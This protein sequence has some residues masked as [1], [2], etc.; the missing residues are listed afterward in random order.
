LKYS[1]INY[2]SEWDA[3]KLTNKTDKEGN[4]KRGAVLIPDTTNSTTV[5]YTYLIKEIDT[6]SHTITV[7]EDQTDPSNGKRCRHRLLIIYGQLIRDQI[8]DATN[9]VYRTVKFFD[10]T[11]TNS[12]ADGDGTRDGVCEVCHTKTRHFQNDGTSE[13][14]L[15][16][17]TGFGE[18]AGTACTNCHAHANGFA[19]GD[20]SIG[21]GC[22]RCHGHDAGTFY[23][24]DMSLP[25]AAGTEQS[26]GRGTHQSH[27][28][29]TESNSEISPSSAGEDDRRGPGIYCSTCHN[30]SKF[31]RFRSKADPN[32][33]LTLSQTDICDTCHSPDGTYNGV[34]DPVIGAKANWHDGIYAADG[35]LKAGKEKW[36]AGCH[37]EVPGNS[38][39][40][41]SGVNAP[42]VIGDEDG[43]Y[44][45]GTGWG[46][47]KT[48][49]GLAAEE[50][51]PYKGGLIPPLLV[52]GA[53]RPVN[54][55]GCHVFTTSHIDGNARTFENGSSDTLDPSY[56]RKGYRLKQVL[57]G[58]GTGQA[59]KS[60]ARPGRAGPIF[61]ITPT[62][63]VCV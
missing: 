11:G 44:T 21:G 24:P 13:D 49:H 6:V 40:D 26:Q 41:G 32:A 48:G 4:D 35:S 31:P 60:Y 58:M 20:G 15:H 17:S 8:Y 51:Y 50:A 56:Y 61:R 7:I 23:D 12:F 47:Y 63:T 2:R 9:S 54:C 42:N 19:H 36:C 45:Y 18:V 25:Y 10:R 5:K 27:S 38:K 53:S 33:E 30:T 55:D 22:V 29:H 57:S 59:R 1:T 46:F 28:T 39:P 37:D 34:N 3:S 16:T 52:N 43:S 62:I 14:Q